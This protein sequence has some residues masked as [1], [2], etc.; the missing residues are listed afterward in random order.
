V[1]GWSRERFPSSVTSGS[2]RPPPSHCVR[3]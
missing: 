3:L 1:Q 2:P